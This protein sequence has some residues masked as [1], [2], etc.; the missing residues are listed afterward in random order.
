MLQT[1]GNN[2]ASTP[3]D[4]KFGQQEIIIIAIV[5]ALAVTSILLAALVLF[6]VKKKKT[7]S[8]PPMTLQ[9]NATYNSNSLGS[10]LKIEY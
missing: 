4:T 5:A 9:S 10:K 7:K 2:P 1:R 8:Q 6:L 3:N